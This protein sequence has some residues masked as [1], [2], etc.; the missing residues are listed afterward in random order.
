MMIQISVKCLSLK[1]FKYRGFDF[2]FR[3]SIKSKQS[4]CSA[5]CS[6]S[7]TGRELIQLMIRIISQ[8]VPDKGSKEKNMGICSLHRSFHL[9]GFFTCIYIYMYL[10]IKVWLE[11]GVVS[12]SGPPLLVPYL[13]G[14][15]ATHGLFVWI[16]CCRLIG[17][18]FPYLFAF[19]VPARIIS[20][21]GHAV[22]CDPVAA[23]HSADCLCSV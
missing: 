4:D 5:Y 14:S 3:T 2:C 9:Q 23:V 16:H 13:S 8:S 12:R 19:W 10:Y 17:H 11:L 22:H 15:F 21:V 20:G 7:K 6:C 18:W 1:W